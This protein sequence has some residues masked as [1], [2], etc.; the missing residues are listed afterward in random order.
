LQEPVTFFVEAIE[1]STIIMISYDAEQQLM[2]KYPRFERFYRIISQLTAIHAQRR[3]LSNISQTAEERYDNFV[4]LYP[5]LLQ[6]FPLYMIASY[7]GMTREF[8]SKI[9]NRNLKKLAP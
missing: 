8:L 5:Q 4:T 3:L 6:R 7:L 1:D 9:R 2:N